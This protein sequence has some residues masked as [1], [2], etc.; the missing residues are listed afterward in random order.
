T[1]GDALPF[2]FGMSAI[3]IAG[4]IALL[5]RRPATRILPITGAA[6]FMTL[7]GLMGRFA[8]YEDPSPM[9]QRLLPHLQPDGQILQFKTF[10]PS[11]MYYTRRPSVIVDFANRSGLDEEEY[12]TS[13]DFVDNHDA[14]A[15]ALA[16][17]KQ[18]FVL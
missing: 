10:Q 18:V 12:E 8:L 9:I 2:V 5:L 1:G 16:T 11:V 14:I 7:T 3:L 6:L 4:A 15:N 17:G 13:G